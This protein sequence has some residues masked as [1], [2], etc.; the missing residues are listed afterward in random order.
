MNK[1]VFFI[2]ALL[3]AVVQGAWAKTEAGTNEAQ[4]ADEP[5]T[6]GTTTTSSWLRRRKANN[7]ALLEA[8]TKKIG[9][10]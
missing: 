1:K 8:N 2:L 7:A 9:F 10:T 5:P 4:L 3:C 6:R